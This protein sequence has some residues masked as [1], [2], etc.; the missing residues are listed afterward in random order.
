[1]D[2]VEENSNYYSEYWEEMANQVNFTDSQKKFIMK[3]KKKILSEK[4]KFEE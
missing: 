1:M 2:F 4:T 3:Y